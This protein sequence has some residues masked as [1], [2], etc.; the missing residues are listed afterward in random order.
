M[1]KK[2]EISITVETLARGFKIEFAAEGQLSEEAYCST[3]AQ[4]PQTIKNMVAPLFAEK[5]S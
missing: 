1:G 5:K 4:I 3:E 2:I